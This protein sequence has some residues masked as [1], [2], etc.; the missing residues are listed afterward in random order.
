MRPSY[1]EINLDSIV[2]N[3][4]TLKKLIPTETEFMAVVKANA[5]GYGLIEVAERLSLEGVKNFAVAIIEEGIE[6]RNAGIEGRI[7]ILGYVPKDDYDDIVKYNLTPTVYN[8]EQ[9]NL[10]S[11]VAKKHNTNLKIHLKIDTG[12]SRLGFSFDDDGVEQ[13]ESINSLENIIIEGI[14]SHLATGDI[15][16]DS[17]AKHQFTT[18]NSM[19]VELEKKGVFI[20][21]K[22][23]ANSG[24]TIN[25]PEFSLNMVRIGT[26]LYG[27]YPNA[28]MSKERKINLVQAMTIK[29]VIASIRTIQKGTSVGYG[30]NYIAEK[31][32][33]IGIIPI[34]YVD[35]IT[36]SL[37]N[38]GYVL[39]RGVRCKIIGNIC[40]DQFMVD[41]SEISNPEV[42]EE[43]IIMGKQRNNEITAEEIGELTNTVS[44]E[45]ISKVS[46]R[47]PR[48][49][50]G[51]I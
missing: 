19:I 4:N 29:S 14:F 20:P 27:L 34:G 37:S 9:A 51:R 13:I 41:V 24:G 33:T 40:M 10:L 31:I 6:L 47:V 38:R 8:Y 35:G 18:L 45:F 23:I 5:Y 39:I 22:H 11:Q 44:I 21:I 2:Y 50:Y 26:S 15:P 46:T 1:V 7:L 32:T 12:M 48:I 16:K 25:Y 42:G 49:F 17:F 28:K 30:R 43:V 3:Y 36:R